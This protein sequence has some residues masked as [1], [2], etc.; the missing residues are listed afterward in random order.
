MNAGR[1]RDDSLERLQVSLTEFERGLCFAVSMFT[2][3]LRSVLYDHNDND[4][5]ED[6]V[7]WE[8]WT[9]FVRDSRVSM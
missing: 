7:A 5:S 4:A 1:I 9:R 2:E 3:S 6:P 8:P